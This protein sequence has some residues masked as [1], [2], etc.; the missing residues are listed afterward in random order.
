[1]SDV[2]PIL[3][4]WMNLLVRERNFQVYLNL[5]RDFCSHVC[6]LLDIEKVSHLQLLSKPTPNQ[7]SNI[8][9]SNKHTVQS[10]VG[11]FSSHTLKLFQPVSKLMTWHHPN[12]KFVLIWTLPFQTLTMSVH[13]YQWIGKFGS[14]TISCS[15]LFSSQVVFVLDHSTVLLRERLSSTPERLVYGLCC[16][17][18]DDRRHFAFIN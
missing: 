7:W 18:L 2:W 3:S 6:A 16:F 5:I 11:R 9:H 8:V 12:L 17:Q 13:P 4:L 14:Y 10:K 1:M 15:K